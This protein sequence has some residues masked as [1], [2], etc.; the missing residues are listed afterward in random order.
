MLIIYYIE[1]KNVIKIDTFK[2][3]K[4][5][6]NSIISEISDVEKIRIDRIFKINIDSDTNEIIIDTIRPIKITLNI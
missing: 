2:Y 1:E 5:S 4:D 6:I 3:D